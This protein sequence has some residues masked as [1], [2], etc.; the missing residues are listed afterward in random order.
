MKILAYHHATLFAR[1][2]DLSVRFFR[3]TLGMTLMPHKEFTKENVRFFQATNGSQIH[4]LQ[5]D[6]TN[7]RLH[8]AMEVDDLD[9][10]R[11]RVVSAGCR[12]EHEP[13]RRPDGSRFF[14]CRD[15][16]GNRVEFTST[17]D[18]TWWIL[19]DRRLPEDSRLVPLHGCYGTAVVPKTR[20]GIPRWDYGLTGWW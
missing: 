7:E 11:R 17:A 1:D 6:D 20:S 9:E 19:G 5:D 18:G 16:E 4:V 2:L 8:V 3:D 14:F 13:N 10:V 15:F 12:I